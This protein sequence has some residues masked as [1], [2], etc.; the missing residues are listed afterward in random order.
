MSKQ[1]NMGIA[2]EEDSVRRLSNLASRVAPELNTTPYNKG[3]HTGS[4]H[5]VSNHYDRMDKEERKGSVNRILSDLTD[6]RAPGACHYYDKYNYKIGI[7]AD[8][9]LYN[10]FSGIAEMVYI[11]YEA[12]L[13][14]YKELDLMIVATTWNGIDGSWKGVAVPNNHK[15]TRLEEMIRV[16]RGNDIPVAFYSKEDPVNYERYKDIALWCDY[17]FTSAIEMVPVYEAYT[18]NPNVHPMMFGL[19]PFIHNP[20]DTHNTSFDEV[21]FAGS[22]LTKYPVRMKETEMIFDGILQSDKSLMIF[23]RNFYLNRQTY[24]F[25]ENYHDSILPAIEHSSLMQLHKAYQYFVNLNSVKYSETMF[26]N[27]IVELQ[28]FGNILLTNYNTGVN[29][30]FPNIKIV[31]S[32]KDVEMYL[33]MDDDEISLKRDNNIRTVY[34]GHTTFDRMG[35][36]LAICLGLQGNNRKNVLVVL[37]SESSL[38]SFN[39][40]IFEGIEYVTEEQFT[41]GL[42]QDYDYITYF[43]DDILYEEY[44]IADMVTGFKFTDSEFIT[45]NRQEEKHTYTTCYDSHWLTLFSAEYILMGEP[46][47]QGKGY[48][49]NSFEFKETVKMTVGT[50]PERKE[51]SI[52]VPIH[53]NGKY[54][55]EKC[56]ASLKRSQSFGKFEIIFVDDGSSDATTLKIIDRL[57]R[58]HPDILYYRFPDGSGSA[59]RPR[60]KGVELATTGYITYLDPDNEAI[61]DS[62]HDML[63]RIKEDDS[64]DMVVGNIVKE[65]NNKRTE[66]TYTHYIKKHNNGSLEVDD[67][68]SFLIRS[69]LRAQSIQALAVKKEIIVDNGLK[70]TEGAAGQD[71]L[72][73]QELFLKC[74]KVMGMDQLIHVYYGSVTGSVTNSVSSNLFKKYYV[75]ESERVAFLKREGIF[76]QYL[77]KR[78]NYYVKNWYLPRLEKVEGSDK[79][80]AEGYLAK[81]LKY[82]GNYE[83]YVDEELKQ[84][85]DQI[86]VK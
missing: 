9:F 68:K 53:N 54:L 17:I 65:D 10:A 79:E 52:V 13:E 80:V 85:L 29:N 34:D 50:L 33:G 69:G 7:I 36:I 76:H 4:A 5:E 24:Q 60:N 28:G 56:F 32:S 18:G 78:F 40:Q 47:Q 16:M 38:P 23:D 31:N 83:F 37:E 27:R 74:R 63:E 45:N 59:S 58:Q 49:Y 1:W 61:G 30:H 62:Y 25:P 70:M 41:R 48:N 84:K 64:I 6:A 44:Y 75:L 21:I 39:R 66:L 67:T 12:D 14:M 2:G 77:S 57:R 26:A 15:R 22:W 20:I 81:I 19:N 55:E 86:K 8:E 11:P 43:S 35:E 46:G 82:Y 73:F 51:M 71:T 3:V 42:L 72:F